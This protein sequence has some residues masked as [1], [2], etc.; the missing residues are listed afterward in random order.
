MF[1]PTFRVIT[2]EQTGC[3]GKLHESQMIKFD[4]KIGMTSHVISLET[5]D[6]FDEFMA[7]SWHSWNTSWR[8]I[9]YIFVEFT[10][11]K[12]CLNLELGNMQVE[13][14]CQI[15]KHTIKTERDDRCVSLHVVG[16]IRL[17]ISTGKHTIVTGRNF[18]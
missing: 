3:A 4:A 6:G 10:I 16:I 12:R 8:H 13:T 2:T 15:W 7:H 14:Y 5:I 1:M 9:P 18:Q 11:K 17:E